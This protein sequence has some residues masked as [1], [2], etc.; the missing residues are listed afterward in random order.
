MLTVTMLMMLM[1]TPNPNLTVMMMLMMLMRPVSH[2]LQDGM[3][4][5]RRFS[6]ALVGSSVSACMRTHPPD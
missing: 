1:L 3:P 4:F 2:R 5:H 6:S